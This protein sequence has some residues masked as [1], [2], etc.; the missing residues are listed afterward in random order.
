MGKI[1]R[2]YYPH[3]QIPDTEERKQTLAIAKNYKSPH[4]WIGEREKTRSLAPEPDTYEFDANGNGIA[5]EF[6]Y[7]VFFKLTSHFVHSTVCALDSHMGERYDVFRVRAAWVPNKHAKFTL[8]N[9]LAMV[10]KTFICGFRA[11]RQDQPEEILAEMHNKMQ[12][13]K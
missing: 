12:S 4:E 13:Y 6:D 2:K 11:I 7:E 8:F 3:R 9:V 10:S 1:I 5:A